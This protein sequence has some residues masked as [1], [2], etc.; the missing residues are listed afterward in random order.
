MQIKHLDLL[1][2]SVPEDAATRKLSLNLRSLCVSVCGTLQ[3][4][5][6]VQAKFRKSNKGLCFT[7]LR[8]P[9]RDNKR[10][11]G[12]LPDGFAETAEPDKRGSTLPCR[13]GAHGDGTEPQRLVD[14]SN[15]SSTARSVVQFLRVGADPDDQEGEP[16]VARRVRAGFV[17]HAVE[18]EW[19]WCA[20]LVVAV[21]RVI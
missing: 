11:A 13:V 3:D 10:R 9:L 2:F 1:V 16:G 18:R 4:S 14:R 21:Q 12:A 6:R 7:R 20:G 5:N 19:Q 8:S 15:V 17:L